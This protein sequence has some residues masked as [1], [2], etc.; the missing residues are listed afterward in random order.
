M[1]KIPS[2]QRERVFER[3]TTHVDVWRT[4]GTEKTR[5][6]RE[7]EVERKGEKGGSSKEGTIY[8][9]EDREF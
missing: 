9:D 6:C 3:R 8:G 5:G 1:Q 7:N 4:G 2:F